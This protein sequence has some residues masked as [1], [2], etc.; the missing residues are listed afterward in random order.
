MIWKDP[1]P[2]NTAPLIAVSG[3][4]AAGKRY[5]V[6]MGDSLW[7]ISQLFGVS[8]TA[9]RQ[10]NAISE[11]EILQ[12]GQELKVSDPDNSIEI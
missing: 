3:T 12:P 11:K 4:S 7:A 8:V 5:T 1:P 9:L 10:W 2:S 6:R